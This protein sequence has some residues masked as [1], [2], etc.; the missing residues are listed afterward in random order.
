MIGP[1]GLALL[2][3]FERCRLSA[4]DDG[5]GYQTI[6]WGHTGGVKP[7]DTCTQEQADA[8]LLDDLKVAEWAVKTSVAVAITESQRDA[9]AVLAYNIGGT[10]FAGSEVVKA[11]NSAHH[12]VAARAFLGWTMAGGRPLRGLLRRRLAEASLYAEDPWEKVEQVST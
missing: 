4:Y 7:E 3:S 6:G 9:L 11:V 1:R 10:A 5:A 8:W 2:K 12:F